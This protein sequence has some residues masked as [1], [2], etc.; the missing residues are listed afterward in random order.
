MHN[1]ANLNTVK[2][3]GFFQVTT[4]TGRD[5]YV[6]IKDAGVQEELKPMHGISLNGTEVKSLKM[7]IIA[8]KVL[9]QKPDG[10]WFE[11]YENDLQ[12]AAINYLKNKGCTITLNNK[13]L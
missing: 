10:E 3:H 8:N 2:G 7:G 13:K 4:A 9:I 1:N 11:A 12:V 6:N 5:I